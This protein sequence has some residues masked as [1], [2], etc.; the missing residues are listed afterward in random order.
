MSKLDQQLDEESVFSRKSKLSTSPARARTFTYVESED[1]EKYEETER[2]ALE[3]RKKWFM[4]NVGGELLL[5]KQRKKLEN[6]KIIHVETKSS[7]KTMDKVTLD[8]EKSNWYILGAKEPKEDWSDQKLEENREKMYV[9]LQ[10]LREGRTRHKP[11][12]KPKK[13]KKAV[14][15]NKA[16]PTNME[17]RLRQEREE[18]R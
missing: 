12:S 11:A 7:I 10:K 16:I 8:T 3:K 13:K 5:H 17:G 18:R 9:T 6:G 15:P 1:G 2:Q 14:K 4:D